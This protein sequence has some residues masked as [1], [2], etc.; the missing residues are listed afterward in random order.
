MGMNS[1]QNLGPS[2]YT[3][4]QTAKLSQTDQAVVA[5][6]NQKAAETDLTQQTAN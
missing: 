5:K 1:I 2:Q 3:I 6:Q 4:P